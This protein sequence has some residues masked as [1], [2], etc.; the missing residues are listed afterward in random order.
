MF[1]ELTIGL[2]VAFGYILGPLLGNWT[3]DEQVKLKKWL[4]KYKKYIWL[5]SVAYGV[6]LWVSFLYGFEVFGS[7]TIFGLI[8]AETSLFYD[9]KLDK[10]S[11]KQGLIF[12][13]AF[14]LPVLLK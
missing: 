3:M 13:L 9:T 10:D 2:A 1:Q 5:D 11:I 7:L 8:I 14:S 4:K 12:L 6:L